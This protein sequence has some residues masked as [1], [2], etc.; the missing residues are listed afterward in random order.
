MKSLSIYVRA[1]LSA[2]HVYV[3]VSRRR[4]PVRLVLVPAERQS[5]AP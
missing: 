2:K 5:Y 1:R 3:R 4:D